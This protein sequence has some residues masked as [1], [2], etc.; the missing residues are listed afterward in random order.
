MDSWQSQGYPVGIL[1]AAYIIKML[2]VDAGDV[3]SE[4]DNH[5]QCTTVTG[6]LNQE[7]LSGFNDVSSSVRVL[8]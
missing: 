4:L 2:N 6:H 5:I 3:F 7:F 8:G 1:L